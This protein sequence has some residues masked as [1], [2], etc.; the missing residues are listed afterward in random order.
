[1][2]IC[3]LLAII[4]PL[5]GEAGSAADS[6]WLERAIDT[7]CEQFRPHDHPEFTTYLNMYS[8]VSGLLAILLVALVCGA[9]GS[10]V[11]GNRMAFFS[12]A[13]AH[14]A[15][16]G[17]SLGF[18]T[19]LFTGALQ[20]GRVNFFDWATPI[21]VGFGI[22]VGIAI[23][24]VREKTSLSSDTVIG[25]FFAGAMGFGAMLLQGIAQF[26]KH[27]FEPEK[28]L[29]G[30]ASAVSSSDLKLLFVLVLLTGVV[31]SF[32]YNQL[33]FTSFNP[34]LART[35]RVPVRLCSYLFI[36]LLAI[37]INLCL[38]TVGALLI[39][40]LLIVP[41]A[42]AGNLVRNLRQMFWVTIGLAVTVGV[43]GHALSYHLRPRL[44]DGS[45]LQFGVG[46]LVVVLSVLLFF[47]SMALVSLRRALNRKRAHAEA[48]HSHEE[49]P[50][51]APITR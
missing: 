22:T 41:A 44:P 30:T 4:S 1:V 32:L 48:P 24:F 39:N 11:I 17:I 18:L 28:F 26:G 50:R 10:L 51:P 37:I 31:L 35:R 14:C 49:H 9:V 33:L 43:T 19:A 36:V 25:V 40:A 3:C 27:Y 47:A 5:L 16:A 38:K 21:M 6:D 2:H 12:D 23:A 8:T 7:F 20:N 29:F 15:F 46:G 45:R 13:L 42:T 34:S